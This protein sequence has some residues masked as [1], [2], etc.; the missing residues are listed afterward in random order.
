MSDRASERV[1]GYFPL[2]IATSIAIEKILGYVTDDTGMTSRLASMPVSG[3]NKLWINVATLY[4]NIFGA[5]PKDQDYS[6]SSMTYAVVL[7]AEME[8]IRGLLAEHAPEVEVVFYL[9]NHRNLATAYPGAIVRETKAPRQVEYRKKLIQTVGYALTIAEQTS[10]PIRLFTNDAIIHGSY[11]VLLLS[12][13]AI[14]LLS[15]PKL[16]TLDLLES[17]TGAIKPKALWYSKLITAKQMPNI[18]FN[19]LT[20]VVFGDSETFSPQPHAVK[21]ALLAVADKKYWTAVTS[22]ERV[23]AHL[24]EVKDPTVREHLKL[25]VK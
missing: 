4:R 7:V 25:I 13:M 21:T 23:K 22:Y 6:V 17:H 3:Y 2:S 24:S 11:R 9:A 15:E 18:P 16:H 19:K 10:Q 14:D 1:L 12:H 20:L 5:M 8:Q